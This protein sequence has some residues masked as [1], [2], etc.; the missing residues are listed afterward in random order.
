MQL[1]NSNGKPSIFHHFSNDLYNNSEGFILC[2]G[3]G[4]RSV[5]DLLLPRTIL[6]NPHHIRQ[7]QQIQPP[8]REVSLIK[9]Q[10]LVFR[11]TQFLCKLKPD[12][13]RRLMVLGNPHHLLQLRQIQPPFAET[14][15]IWDQF[16]C[17]TVFQ[18]T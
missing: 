11:S 14:N 12:F 10:I 16:R 5:T 6:G 3:V 17:L 1:K 18:Q 13:I 7:L 15:L 8:F 2:A 9:R 4:R